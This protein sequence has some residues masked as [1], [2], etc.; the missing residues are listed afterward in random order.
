MTPGQRRQRAS[1]AAPP[2]SPFSTG[3]GR[4]D[5]GGAGRVSCS[6]GLS[7]RSRL[8]LLRRR[9]V[10]VPSTAVPILLARHRRYI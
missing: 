9:L 4:G 5:A 10:L 6:A 3:F 7:S 8:P 1:S 2:C